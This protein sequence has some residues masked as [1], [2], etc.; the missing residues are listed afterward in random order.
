MKD[1]VLADIIASARVGYARAGGRGLLEGLY[2]AQKN[3]FLQ[4]KLDATTLAETC[5]LMGRRQEALRLLDGAYNRREANLLSC[6]SRPDLLTL[7]D[8]PGYKALVKKINFPVNSAKA[9]PTY[10]AELAKQPLQRS[11]N[12]H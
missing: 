1:P 9:S 4:G 8:D 11:T 6:L 5:V 2:S 7:K 3:Y 10:L 12:P